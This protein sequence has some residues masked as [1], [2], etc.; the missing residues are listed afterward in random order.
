VFCSNAALRQPLRIAARVDSGGAVVPADSLHVYGPRAQRARPITMS[1]SGVNVMDVNRSSRSAAH[2]CQRGERRRPGTDEP[3]TEFARTSATVDTRC[4]RSCHS[5]SG[6][7][8]TTRTTSVGPVPVRES[9]DSTLGRWDDARS[10]YAA[11]AGGR[12]NEYGAQQAGPRRCFFL[13]AGWV[14]ADGS[15]GTVPFRACRDAID[16]IVRMWR[17]P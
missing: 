17:E 7:V 5:A 10:R 1:M 11:N 8:S 14:Q 9:Y 6:A 3:R 15:R 2:A 4:R 12:S 16:N 13:D